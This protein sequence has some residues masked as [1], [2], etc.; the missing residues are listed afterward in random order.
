MRLSPLLQ[1][2]V[3]KLLLDLQ[4]PFG[5]ERL[6]DGVELAHDELPS[7]ARERRLEGLCA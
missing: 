6:L 1:E 5:F 3:Q 2:H 4:D 7:L